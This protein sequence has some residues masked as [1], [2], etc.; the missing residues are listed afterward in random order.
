MEY[1]III[2]NEHIHIVSVKKD[3]VEKIYKKIPHA[4]KQTNKNK[5][6]FPGEEEHYF[7]HEVKE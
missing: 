6:H 4:H 1:L 5:E 2:H 7:S 3:T